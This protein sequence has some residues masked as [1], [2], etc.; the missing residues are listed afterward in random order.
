MHRRF[1]IEKRVTGY[2]AV[3]PNKNAAYIPH[4]ILNRRILRRT[5]RIQNPERIDIY[6]INKLI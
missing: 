2:A 1:Q 5:I 6:M 4:R 3:N